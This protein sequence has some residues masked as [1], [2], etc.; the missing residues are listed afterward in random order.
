MEKKFKIVYKTE[1]NEEHTVYFEDFGSL[2]SCYCELMKS[3][4]NI[5]FVYSGKIQNN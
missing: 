3:G 5:R 2:Q 4:K 1:N